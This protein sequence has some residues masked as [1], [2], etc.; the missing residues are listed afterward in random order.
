[1]L[2]ANLQSVV[3][4]SFAMTIFRCISAW[5]APSIYALSL[6]LELFNSVERSVHVKHLISSHLN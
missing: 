6:K 3:A 1:M 4:Y 2:N 5:P